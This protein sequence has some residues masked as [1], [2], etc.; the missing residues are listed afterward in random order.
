MREN[1][2]VLSKCTDLTNGVALGGIPWCRRP[3]GCRMLH[4]MP[5]KSWFARLHQA[6]RDGAIATV[7]SVIYRS[8]NSSII[9]V[10]PVQAGDCSP[11]HAFQAGERQGLCWALKI[12]CIDSFG[13]WA[14]NKYSE[15]DRSPTV[16]NRAVAGATRRTGEKGCIRAINSMS[17][18][19]SFVWSGAAWS[20]LRQ[21]FIRCTGRCTLKCTGVH[22]SGKAK[23]AKP[24]RQ[25]EN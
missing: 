17:P 10:H 9:L 20:R 14:D 1:P 24:C 3:S 6:G 15:N 5:T 21:R 22:L 18:N 13:T 7:T 2:D 4:V 23:L 25:G 11:H 12:M 8:C 16:P 19:F